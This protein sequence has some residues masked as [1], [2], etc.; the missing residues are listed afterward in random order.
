MFQYALLL[1]LRKSFP[2]RRFYLNVETLQLQ[3]CYH[4]Y[5]LDTIFGVE[6]NVI[7]PKELL[8]Q[9]DTIPQKYVR[10]IDKCVYIEDSSHPVWIIDVCWQSEMCFEDFI[11]DYLRFDYSKFNEQSKRLLEKIRNAEKSVAIYARRGDDDSVREI[12]T[13]NSDGA[14]RNRRY[15]RD[16]VSQFDADSRYVVFSDDT[17]WCQ[18]HLDLP[19]VVYVTHNKGDDNWHDM[20]L[21]SACGNQVIANDSFSWWAAWLN[22]NPRKIVIAPSKWCDNIKDQELIPTS[23]RLVGPRMTEVRYDDLTIVITV[24]IDSDERRRKLDFLLSDLTKYRGLQIIVLEADNAPVSVIMKVYERLS[25]A[26]AIRCSIARN[27]S[28]S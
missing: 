27:I 8:D 9:I 10:Y 4:G 17:A 20:A 15:Y 28:T 22:P 26:I 24:R 18:E 23:R 11:K 5:Q 6:Q 25:S 13:H 12:K 16:A 19:E 3:K 1:Q 14:I 21:M 2:E 7:A